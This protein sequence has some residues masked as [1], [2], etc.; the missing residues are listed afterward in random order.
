VGATVDLGQA[1]GHHR[2][3]AMV[4]FSPPVAV[5]YLR[6]DRL[7][8][9][10]FRQSDFDAY[11]VNQADPVV[12]QHEGGPLDRRTAWRQ[13]AAGAGTWMLQGTGWWAISHGETGI[14]AGVVGLFYRDGFTDLEIGWTIMRRFWRQGFASEA[15]AEALRFARHA[16]GADRVV[17]LINPANVASIGVARRIGMH[18]EA[19][20][21]FCDGRTGQWVTSAG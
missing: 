9:R 13:F 14:F 10:E 11:A 16:R 20:V 18:H 19:D 12:M 17:A 7:L 4:D 6:T 2:S 3:L 15:A 5:P 21:P 8:L 1:S